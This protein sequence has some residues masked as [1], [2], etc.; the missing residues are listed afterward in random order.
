MHIRFHDTFSK[1][2]YIDLQIT[3]TDMPIYELNGV[4][5]KVKGTIQLVVTM[6]HR[7]VYQTAQT[8]CSAL[9]RMVYIF[10]GMVVVYIFSK[11]CI[12]VR[13]WLEILLPWFK[14]HRI[15]L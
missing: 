6:G 7:G 11:P 9:P 5:S 10:C 8:A 1:M 13:S 15:L 2:G 12:A 14:P 3:P 4:E